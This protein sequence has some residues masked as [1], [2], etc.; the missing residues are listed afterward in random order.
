MTMCSL[1]NFCNTGDR[2]QNIS[3]NYVIKIAIIAALKKKDMQ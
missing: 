2:Q 1:N 3:D